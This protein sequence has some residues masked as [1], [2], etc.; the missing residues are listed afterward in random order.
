[1]AF[2]HLPPLPL[3][4]SALPSCL[5]TDLAEDT[6]LPGALK[7]GPRCACPARV[8][9]AKEVSSTGQDSRRMGHKR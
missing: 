1:M 6:W 2:P 4:T 7:P 5:P 3:L 8:S 9:A